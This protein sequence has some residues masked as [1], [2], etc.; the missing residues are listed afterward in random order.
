LDQVTVLKQSP[1]VVGRSSYR[2]ILSNRS[3]FA[4]WLA[5]T[6]SQTGDY[7]FNVALLWYVLESTGSIFFVGLTQ[8]VVATPVALI[9]PIA[10]VYVDRFNRKNVMLVSALF[11]G[12]TVAVFATLFI[13]GKLEFPV[14]LSLV[15]LLFS[16]QQFFCLCPKCIHP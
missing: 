1:R 14:L 16:G 7:A 9:G 12:A 3:I 2:R 8:A 10:G 5:Q 6:V 13:A 4:L 11:Q 15:F